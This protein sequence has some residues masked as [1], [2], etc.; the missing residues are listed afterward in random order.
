MTSTDRKPASS[1][2]HKKKASSKIVLTKEQKEQIKEAFDILDTDGNGIISVEDVQMALE[3]LGFEPKEEETVRRVAD[4]VKEASGTID[5]GDFLSI[6]NLKVNEKESKE[7]VLKAFR[8][9]DVDSKGK[10]SFKNLKRV[11]KES[12]LNLTDEQLQEMI[13]EA[14]QDGHGEVGEQ[15]FLRRMKK[16][17]LY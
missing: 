12:G 15:E 5:F 1:S 10:I 6:V 2:G 11:A 7:L 16:A 17:N 9:F 4:I 8:R 3:G 14:D 13:D